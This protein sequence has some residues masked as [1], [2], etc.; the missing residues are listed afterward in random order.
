MPKFGLIFPQ[1]KLLRISGLFLLLPCFAFAQD[2]GTI[3]GLVTDPSGSLIPSAKVVVENPS[4]NF[5][6]DAMS[7]SDG[8]YSLVNLPVGDYKVTVTKDGFRSAETPRVHVDVNTTTHVDVQL[9]VGST[10]DVVEVQSNVSLLQTDRSDLG[11]VI[12]NRAINDLP[13]F[14]NGGLRS[15]VAFTSLAP[16][17]NTNLTGDPDSTTAN[18]RIAG[19]LA[20]GASQLLDGSE[21]QSERKND[22]QMRVVSAEGIEEFK[23]QTSAYSAEFGR[24]SNGILNYT[25]KSGTNEFH[26]T[27][28]G[29]I[30][31]QALN[32]SGFFYTAPTVHNPVIHNQNLEAASFGGPI[33]IPKVIDLRNK[34]FFFLSG[35]RSRAKDVSNSGLISLAPAAFRNGDFRG[36]TD[37]SGNVIPLYD[38]FD[39]S[40]NLISD[41]SQ[42][43]RLSCNGVLNV[44]CPSRINPVAAL[45]ESNVPLPT[46]GNAFLNNN[47][48][49]NNGS[50]TPGENQGVYAVKGDYNATQNMHFSGVFSRQYFNSY[51]LQGPIPGP[52]S[53]AFQE[54]GTTKWV[55]L[56]GDQTITSNLLNHF[57][58][59]YNQ[60]DLGEQGQYEPRPTRRSL[61]KSYADSRRYEL[62]KVAEL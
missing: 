55:R 24:A 39:G 4:T 58:F 56:N 59:G 48:I 1:V 6:K 3:S 49:V 9:Q 30:R 33:R 12:N 62:W 16:G 42:R 57:A 34:A 60:R 35:E 45:I 43:Q 11:Q 61:W 32:A 53:E 5:S 27:A 31:N 7:G 10:R 18:I 22:P 19:G 28:F 44:I 20:N 37:A 14:A 46:N 36:L 41:A 47:A 40:G 21:A 51:T 29:I 13:L 50:R 23:V 52:V 17:V 38:P 15:N 54:F 8:T 25:T 26:G 2:R